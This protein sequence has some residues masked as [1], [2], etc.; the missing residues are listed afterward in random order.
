MIVSLL[1]TLP[2]N[3]VALT[4]MLALV[5]FTVI[6]LEL[7]MLLMNVET[8]C[9]LMLEKLLAIGLNWKSRFGLRC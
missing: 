4:T 2:K 6:R 9:V 7:V 5:A 8:L 1:V 3:E